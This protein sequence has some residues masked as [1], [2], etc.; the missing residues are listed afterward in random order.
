MTTK[1][2]VIL[3]AVAALLVAIG[4]I[5]WRA[6]SGAFTGRATQTAQDQAN[7][8]LVAAEGDPSAPKAVI[9]GIVVDD[10]GAG[11]DGAMVA[12]VR[13]QRRD[14]A[15]TSNHWSKPTAVAVSGGGGRFRFEDVRVGEYAVTAMAEGR[16]AGH[17]QPVLVGPS[18]QV[19]VRVVIEAGFGLSGRVLDVGGGGVPDA[20]VTAVYSTREQ[21]AAPLMFD[22]K[23]KSDGTYRIT[24]RKGQYSLTARAPGYA[25]S[26][27][28]LSLGGDVTH[29]LILQ[30]ASRI[31]GRVVERGTERGVGGAK[32]AL[33]PSGGTGRMGG[34]REVDADD[35]GRFLFDDASAGVFQIQAHH[36]SF[37][38]V[39]NTVAVSVGE[40][41]TDVVVPVSAAHLVSG[42]VVTSDGKP[43]ADALV[44]LFRREPPWGGGRRSKTATDGSFTVKG[45]FAG[46]WHVNVQSDDHPSASQPLTV[47][48]GDVKGLNL[49]LGAAG[50]ID[51]RVVDANGQPVVNAL[52]TA[53][54]MPER[55]GQPFTMVPARRT[56]ADGRFVL[57]PVGAGRLHLSAQHETAGIVRMPPQPLADGEQKTMTL[58]L[59]PSSSIEGTVRFDDGTPAANVTVAAYNTD[60]GFSMGPNPSATTGRDGSYALKTMDPGNY[61]VRAVRS[62]GARGNAD[63]Y[64]PQRIALAVGETKRGVDLKL[65]K[66]GKIIAGLVV[67][68]GKPLPNAMVYL[69]RDTEGRVRAFRWRGEQ[70]PALTD[71]EGKFTIEDIEEGTYVVS[72]EH[73]T[74]AEAEVAGVAAGSTGVKLELPQAASI[75]GV[76]VTEA[77]TPVANAN[78]T[79]VPPIADE[80]DKRARMSAGAFGGDLSTYRIAD[81]SGAFLLGRLAP[82]T[83]DVKATTADGRAA[84]QTVTVTAGEKKTGVRLVV[85]VGLKIVGRVVGMTTNEPLADAMVNLSSPGRSIQAKTGA[86]GRFELAGVTPGESVNLMVHVG[87][88]WV[89][90]RMDVDVPKTREP[91]DV[92]TIPLMKGSWEDRAK[93][94]ANVG[95]GV[96][97][98]WK[99]GRVSTAFVVP[100]GAAEKAGIKLGDV[101]TAVDGKPLGDA[102]AG[103]VYWLLMGKV[104]TKVTMTLEDGR[105]VTLTRELAKPIADKKAT[106][107]AE[108]K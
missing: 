91:I 51:G 80:R 62:A 106:I 42:Q 102:R 46:Q 34:F 4:F 100:G 1:R 99:Q 59:N 58:K 88:D 33:V 23:S 79:V 36:E 20:T 76:L 11:V 108:R 64:D 69:E 104:D 78:V 43:V 82:G 21:V 98:T 31:A 30:P 44:N 25:P 5:R 63:K 37:E 6:G 56:D 94:N 32:V 65:K 57:K 10:K 68:A 71:A 75:A 97:L 72:A 86:D 66:G 39:S 70:P 15:P 92:G 87:Q 29:D 101:V 52:V 48:E 38:G 85:E 107:T 16:G 12:I 49:K 50:K 14:P 77:G 95:V 9:E 81:P 45:V 24:A 22:A 19:D 28:Y 83:Y 55:P 41:A 3:V 60:R 18:D 40:S 47:A 74:F 7:V 103:A 61:E 54:V 105:T 90:E 17:Q 26:N 13:S 73:A 35:A 2:T 89:P 27:A 67:A 8:R 53:D 96:Q 93:N 84:S